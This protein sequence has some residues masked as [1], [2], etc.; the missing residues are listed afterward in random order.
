MSR[1]RVLL[2]VAL[3]AAGWLAVAVRSVQVMVFEHGRF[4]RAAR[5]QQQRTLSVP[6]L[7][8]TIR[9]ADGY[10]LAASLERVAVEVDTRQVR[11]PELFAEAVAPLLGL[12]PRAVRA[13]LDSGRRSVWLA[14][15][16]TREK[17][18]AVKRLAPGAVVLVPDSRRFYPLGRLAAPVVGFVGREALRTVGRAG[19][20]HYYDALLAGEPARYL[21][22]RDA[23]QRQIRLRRVR[24]GRPGFDL[25]LTLDVRL[26][27]A[28]EAVLEETLRRVGG[29]SASA[30]VLDPGTGRVLALASVPSF[31]PAAPGRSPRSTWRLHP[32]QDAYEPGS[33][34][35]PLVAA[36][37]L[38]CRAVRPGE[39]FDCR[40]G[41]ITVA[42]HWIRDHAEPALYTLDGIVSRS[43]N[44]GAVMVAS[45]LAPDLLFATFTGFGL[46]SRTGIG[47]PAEASGVVPPVRRW[48]RL[49]AA[50]LALGQE[51]TASPLQVAAVYA[52]IAN[53]G[54][55]PRPKLVLAASGGRGIAAAGATWPR[56]VMDR[57]LATRIQRMLED[58]VRDGTG[59]RAALP[60]YRVA[61][62]TGTAQRAVDGRFDHRHYVSWFAG[63]L[64]LPRPRVVIVVAVDEPVKD[65]WG[66]SVAAPAF[67]RIAAAAVRLLGIPPRPDAAGG[68]AAARRGR[69]S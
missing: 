64:P 48:S 10:I 36:A 12:S 23:V 8:G 55:L 30:V 31:D 6:S 63:F 29:R 19:L 53:G 21:A 62:K 66:S 7:R 47:F 32:V 16:V 58:V 60:G 52:A 57:R 67:R 65:Y 44:A 35:K 13:R 28:C 40:K 2:V 9:S 15:R 18:A 46:G 45:R 37:A 69:V 11:Y 1:R 38:A 59:K 49:S 20:E 39:L 27:S 56:R 22:V 14:Q 33:T 3:L 41:G 25:V 4:A 61:G 5:R 68:E 54:W 26:Q 50:G 17:G 24:A 34:M 42:G 51:L 43:S